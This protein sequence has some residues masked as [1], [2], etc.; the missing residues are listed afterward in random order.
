MNVCESSTEARAQ[1]KC[2]G[3]L[4]CLAQYPDSIEANQVRCVV[5]V[6]RIVQFTLSIGDIQLSIIHLTDCD[7]AINERH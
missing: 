3:T 2:I 5:H 7:L 4:E 1:V 6:R